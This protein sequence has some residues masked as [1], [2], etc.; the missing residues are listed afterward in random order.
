MYDEN[1]NLLFLHSEIYTYSI[2]DFQRLFTK[3]FAIS[4]CDTGIAFSYN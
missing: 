3:N 4:L 2:T 1:K